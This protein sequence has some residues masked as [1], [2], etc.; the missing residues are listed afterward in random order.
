MEVSG[1]SLRSL[2][3]T[4]QQVYDRQMGSKRQLDWGFVASIS[5]WWDMI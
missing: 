3:E 2:M 4:K 5:K 1:I